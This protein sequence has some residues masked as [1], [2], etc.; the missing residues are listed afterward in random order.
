MGRVPTTHIL[1]RRHVLG[2]L[3]A[4][5][6]APAIA[7][8]PPARVLFV[9]QFGTVKSPFARELLRRRARERGLAVS[10]S[11]RG[12]TPADHATTAFLASARADGVDPR[13]EQVRRLE[14]RDLAQADVVVSFEPPQPA[15]L[16]GARDWSDTPSFG[17]YP[18]ARRNVLA[19]IEA[20][21]DEIARRPCRS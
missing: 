9:C 1:D 18:A 12:L 11:A 21:L 8:C 4:F 17:D 16:P 6:A 15:G 5:A 3:G 20:L 10:V 7:A 13:A 2:A 19:R 14:P